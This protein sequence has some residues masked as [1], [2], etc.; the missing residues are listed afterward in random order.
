ME[1]PERRRCP[2][3]APA[4]PSGP[5]RIAFFEL[6]AQVGDVLFEMGDLLVEGVDVGGGAEAGLVPGPL[7]E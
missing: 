3:G 1:A 4:G 7:A 2:G 6:K 5:R